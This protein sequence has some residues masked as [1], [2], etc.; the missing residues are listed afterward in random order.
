MD[1]SAIVYSTEQKY[2]ANIIHC[3]HVFRNAIE[4][5]PKGSPRRSISFAKL[6]HA[7]EKEGLPVLF[8]CEALIDEIPLI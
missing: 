3:F 2:S 7:I 8:T 5:F 6:A 4:K 1:N